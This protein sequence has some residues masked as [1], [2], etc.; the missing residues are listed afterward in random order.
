MALI[1]FLEKSSKQSQSFHEK[2]TSPEKVQPIPKISSLPFLTA[3][4]LDFRLALAN[5][6]NSSHT[7]SASLVDPDLYNPL[8]CHMIQQR[9]TLFPPSSQGFRFKVIGLR[10]VYTIYQRRTCQIAK[11][12]QKS[13]LFTTGA[14][15]KT[16]EFNIKIFTLG[17][18]ISTISYEIACS[19]EKGI[20]LLQTTPG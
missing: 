14:M 12:T 7:G 9:K 4:L 3:C 8:P 5:P 19:S 11:A 1:Q 13:I 17:L 18:S 20:H 16:N 15:R 6:C 10:L 2:K